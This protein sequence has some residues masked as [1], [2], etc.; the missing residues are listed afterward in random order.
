MDFENAFVNQR[1]NGAYT[2]CCDVEDGP[3][4][5]SAGH[6]GSRI[7]SKLFF[8]MAFYEV[9]WYGMPYNWNELTNLKP[10]SIAIL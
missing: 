5:I 4:C 3:E 7:A 1:M 10:L 6:T 8:K 9:N 2:S